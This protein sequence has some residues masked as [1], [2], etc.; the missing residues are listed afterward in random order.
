MAIREVANMVLGALRGVDLREV[1]K[2]ASGKVLNKC[3]VH[4]LDIENK[5]AT[6][7]K[8]GRRTRAP[9][10]QMSP[11]PVLRES[12]SESKSDVPTVGGCRLRSS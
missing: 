12:Q 8:R 6:N 1:A 9:A 2:M 11:K 10:L 3:T 7:A 5:S 4:E